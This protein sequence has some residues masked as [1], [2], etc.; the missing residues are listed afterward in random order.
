MLMGKWL[1]G[2]TA[3]GECTPCV[4]GMACDVQGM[5]TPIRPCSAGYFCRVGANST[6]PELGADANIC[7]PGS[8]CPEMTAEPIECPEGSYSPSQG[9]QMVEECLN[10]TR[11]YYC[12]T[13]GQ[14]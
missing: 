3:E 7:P 2:L 4:G 12:N 1:S 8:Y 10:C 11:G 5:E 9:L 13:T 6:T 14:I